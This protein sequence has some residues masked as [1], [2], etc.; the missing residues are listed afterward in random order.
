MLTK[1]VKVK[2]YLEGLQISFLNITINEQA[3]ATAP[4]ATVQ[5][6]ATSEALNLLPRTQAHV[7]Y[8]I[9]DKYFLIY[10]G[11][12]ESVSYNQSAFSRNVTL[13][14]VGVF[15]YFSQALRGMGAEGV[16]GDFTNNTV[17]HY[18]YKNR[19]NLAP[20]TIKPKVEEEEGSSGPTVTD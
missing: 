15:N 3:G 8:K 2:L 18:N 11:E 9:D 7:F 20:S 16:E 1:D 17:L 5:V 14:L 13:N 19:V 4:S 12:L 10:E 6:P